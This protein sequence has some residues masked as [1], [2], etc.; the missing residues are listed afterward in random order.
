[1]PLNFIP[2]LKIYKLSQKK[3]TKNKVVYVVINE[4]KNTVTKI[5]V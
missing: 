2:T 5:T 4:N 3:K 1:M